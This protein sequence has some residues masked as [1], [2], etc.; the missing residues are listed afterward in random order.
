MSTIAT[1]S[2]GFVRISCSTAPPAVNPSARYHASDVCV[3]HGATD[4]PTESPEGRCARCSTDAPATVDLD[5][6]AD[7]R[8]RDRGRVDGQRLV[9]RHGDRLLDGLI[10]AAHQRHPSRHRRS[11]RRWPRR[12]S[13]PTSASPPDGTP[14]Q[15]H[16][17]VSPPAGE[18]R[19]STAGDG[20]ERGLDRLL[21]V[22]RRRRQARRDRRP[23]AAR[24][25]SRR[26]ITAPDLAGACRRRLGHRWLDQLLVVAWCRRSRS[27]RSTAAGRRR[28]RH[29]G[30]SAS[31]PARGDAEPPGHRQPAGRH[32]ASDPQHRLA[33]RATTS[34]TT[35][36]RSPASAAPGAADVVRGRDAEPER[37]QRRPGRRR[38]A[39][40]ARPVG[41]RSARPR[42]PR[43]P[44][45]RR[46]PRPRRAPE[47]PRSCRRRPVASTDR[48][49]RLGQ[50]ALELGGR[51]DRGL[52]L[53]AGERRGG[54]RTDEIELA[55]QRLEQP[56]GHGSGSAVVDADAVDERHHDEAHAE[57]RQHA[58]GALRRRAGDLRRSPHAAPRR[59]PG[60]RPPT[61]RAGRPGRRRPAPSRRRR[62]G[63]STGTGS[64]ADRRG[65]A[66]GSRRPRAAVGSSPST[67]STAPTRG[68][69]H[70]PSSTVNTAG[71]SPTMTAAI[72]SRPR[73]CRQPNVRPVTSARTRPPPT[74]PTAPAP[75]PRAPGASRRRAS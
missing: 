43:H 14:G 61:D 66:R 22:P 41:Y 69:Y 31:R 26:R 52:V 11:R 21:A 32:N 3:V 16:V 5:H 55:A 23:S 19:A 40:S 50:R 15:N 30:R 62:R 12:S 45:R 60:R 49:R 73:G 27:G 47:W 1:S 6:R 58:A 70:E 65:T 13:P 29:R 38:A 44:T 25:G 8:R 57:R 2:Y 48:R 75:A 33:R 59:R 72:D 18:A 71:A 9:R 7:V 56:A 46:S 63:R 17:L 37:A 20:R 74:P 64:G 28:A 24:I 42:P 54:D 53:E 34:A 4:T 39:A 35:G 67:S 68:R 36:S 10:R 51:R